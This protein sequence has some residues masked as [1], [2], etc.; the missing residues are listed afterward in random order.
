MARTKGTLRP[1]PH[2]PHVPRTKHE[3][4]SGRMPIEKALYEK[5][6][7]ELRHGDVLPD[8][9]VW[10]TCTLHLLLKFAHG[11]TIALPREVATRICDIAWLAF[12]GSESAWYSLEMQLL[13][14]KEDAE[15]EADV[16]RHVGSTSAMHEDEDPDALNDEE[17]DAALDAYYDYSSSPTF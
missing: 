6:W 11:V 17:F 12:A 3:A 15:A 1:R 14:E 9:F 2:K 7:R 16:N 8:R 4:G 5:W 10:K 13:E